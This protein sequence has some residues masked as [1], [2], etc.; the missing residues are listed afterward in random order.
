MRRR[1]RKNIQHPGRG[2]RSKRFP[3]LSLRQIGSQL[4]VSGSY[5]GRILNGQRNG[6]PELIFSLADI[7]GINPRDVV[8]AKTRED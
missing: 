7:L 5:V 4:G 8:G 2:V 1:S 6:T 3:S